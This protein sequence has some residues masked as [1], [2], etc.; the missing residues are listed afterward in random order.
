LELLHRR[1]LP[2]EMLRF[3]LDDKARPTCRKQLSCTAQGVQLGALNVQL[4]QRGSAWKPGR[5][6]VEPDDV[7]RYG[8][9]CGARL[10]S[11]GV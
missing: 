1:A 10:G 5:Q 9:A 7:D 3:N 6:V 11:E 2:L 4:H 8:M